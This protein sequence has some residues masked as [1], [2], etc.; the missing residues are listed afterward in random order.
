MV[1]FLLP[2]YV[3]SHSSAHFSVPCKTDKYVLGQLNSLDFWLLLRVIVL[4][5]VAQS[6]L[7]LCDP[8]DCSPPGSSLQGNSPGKNTGVSCHAFLQEIF[9]TQQSNSGLLHCRQIL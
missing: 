7:S 8:M 3:H 1:I 5:L 4:C 2:I 6:C 9:P